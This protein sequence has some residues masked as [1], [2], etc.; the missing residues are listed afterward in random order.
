LIKDFLFF[1]CRNQENYEINYEGDNFFEYIY[2]KCSF[3]K[4]KS[5]I[6][7]GNSLYKT[8][9]N[10]NL[11]LCIRSYFLEKV[12]SRVHKKLL[13]GSKCKIKSDFKHYFFHPLSG[14]TF[15]NTAINASLV[16]VNLFH[17]YQEEI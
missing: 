15:L 3:K 17:K 8:L 4:I 2:E 13:H 16:G 9:H 6:I 14:V 11:R 1:D 5:F 7:I 10:G 12:I